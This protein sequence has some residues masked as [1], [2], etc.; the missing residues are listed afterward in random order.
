MGL[1]NVLKLDIMRLE[2]RNAIIRKLSRSGMTHFR[3]FA[4]V[5]SEFDLNRHRCLDVFG[6][7][8]KV[9]NKKRLKKKQKKKARGVI[10]KRQVSRQS[11]GRWRGSTGLRF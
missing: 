6:L 8:A 2:C 10:R 4:H 5:S 1:G 7:D 11:H 9:L 3:D